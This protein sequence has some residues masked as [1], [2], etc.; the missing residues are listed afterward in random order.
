MI[1]LGA[2]TL[3]T[4]GHC[5]LWYAIGD[6]P[7]DRRNPDFALTSTPPTC[8]PEVHRATSTTHRISLPARAPGG[9]SREGP[10]GPRDLDLA[11]SCH[12]LDR[13]KKM[14]DHKYPA[15]NWLLLPK[16]PRRP[17]PRWDDAGADSFPHR[18]RDRSP[19]SPLRFRG[20]SP[21]CCIVPDLRR[22]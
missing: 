19:Y 11:T 7:K 22:N 10:A 2:A 12:P 6:Y 8:E 21:T 20:A 16:R 14:P 15:Q 17:I 4:G 3:M 5:F 18:R 9:L 1:Y 13:R